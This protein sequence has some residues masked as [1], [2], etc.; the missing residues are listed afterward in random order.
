MAMG[1]VSD[2]DFNLEQSKLN[3]PS[4]EKS[5][6]N[7]KPVTNVV[8]SVSIQPVVTPGRK[9][10]DVNVPDSI[11]NLIADTSVAEGRASAIALAKALDISP[12]SVSAYS[13]GATS[14]AS[15]DKTDKDIKAASDA[16]K[17][18]VAKRARSKMMQ[19]LHHI[20]PDKLE[21]AKLRDL[22]GVARD[23]SVIIKN[24]EPEKEKD[25]NTVNNNG[26]QFVFFAPKVE[27]ESNYPVVYSRD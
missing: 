17:L 3:N 6:S 18:R 15:Y 27:S 13:N 21:A 14:T 19:A 20:T 11:R 2:K 1:I 8:P 25:S 12:A 22:A 4:C 5:V 16:A 7:P 26:P 24:M 23:M 9:A 10:N